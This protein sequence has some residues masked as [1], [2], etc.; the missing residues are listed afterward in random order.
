MRG[1]HKRF[2]FVHSVASLIIFLPQH[3]NP[4]KFLLQFNA[5]RISICVNKLAGQLKETEGR[6][7]KEYIKVVPGGMCQTSGECSLC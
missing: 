1:R 3:A 4:S 2:R 5:V 7:V 6:A